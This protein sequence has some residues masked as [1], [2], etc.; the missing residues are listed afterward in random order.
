[1]QAY[2]NLTDIL[3]ESGLFVVQETAPENTTPE[4]DIVFP[5]AFYDYFQLDAA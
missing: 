2:D 3:T 5:P 4:T 1:M